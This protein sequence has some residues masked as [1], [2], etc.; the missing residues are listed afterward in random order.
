M[1]SETT[2]LEY[3]LKCE[4]F[5]AVLSTLPNAPKASIC[6]RLGQAVPQSST[7][8]S[9]LH[10]SKNLHG[11][12]SFGLHKSSRQEEGQSAARTAA[13]LSGRQHSLPGSTD[14]KHSCGA[15]IQAQSFGEPFSVREE[16]EGAPWAE[17][18]PLCS[19]RQTRLSCGS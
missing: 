12:L 7:P 15:Q 14:A 3:F 18:F 16:A 8:T 5:V 2:S 10:F 17:A 19:R 11:L 6:R 13:V 4:H 9:A 1:T